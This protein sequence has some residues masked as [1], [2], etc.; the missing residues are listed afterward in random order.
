MT[1]KDN[2]NV[3]ST[4]VKDLKFR[5]LSSDKST[6]SIGQV[7]G[8]AVVFGQPSE[9]MGFTEY[10][11][12]HAFDGVNMNSV[13]AL[14][15][16]NL[17]NILGRVDSG[18]LELKLDQTGLFFSLEIPDTTVGRDVYTN[19]QNGNL[20]GCSFGFTIA[21]DD[22]EYDAHDNTIHTVNQIDELIEISIT[23]L[24][25]YSQT[26]VG[27]SRGLKKFNE[28]T[29]RKKMSLFLVITESEEL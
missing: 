6:S 29:Y 13:I 1:I 26:S 22:W 21:D 17:D 18:T 10:V 12:P 7:S 15:D 23:A 20:K 14:Y 8:Y 25:A 28:E 19:I 3:R 4:W 11:D 27:V 24:P 2:E 5:D 16:H 9:D